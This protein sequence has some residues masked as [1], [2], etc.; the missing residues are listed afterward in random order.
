MTGIER[1]SGGVLVANRG[2]IAV[3]ILRSISELGIRSCAVYAEDEPDAPH[4]SQ[5]DTAIALVG[6]GV[7]AYLDID[8]IIVAATE[9]GCSAIHPGYGFL[10][11]NAEFARRCE[12]NGLIFIG[13][14]P[15]ELAVFGDKTRARRV[16]RKLGIPVAEGT[17]EPVDLA[18]ARRFMANLAPA[19]SVF[20]KAVMGGGGRG[21]R[22][23]RD[24]DELDAAYLD[25]RSEGE[26]AFGETRLYA[27][28]AIPNARH[29]EVQIIGDEAGAVGHLGERDC[30]VQRRNQK[31]IEVAP[32]VSLGEDL[33]AALLEAALRM[34]RSIHFRGVGTIE[35]LVAPDGKFVFLEGNPRLQVEHTVTE[36]VTGV[37]LVAAQL[38]IAGGASLAELGL[39]RPP[40]ARGFAIQLRVNAVDPD[41][42]VVGRFEPPT[43]AGIRVDTHCHKGYRINPRYDPLLAKVIV[44]CPADDFGVTVTKARHA[45]EQL[46]IDIATNTDLLHAIVQRD[47][48]RSGVVD[49]SFVENM[50]AAAQPTATSA[51]GTITLSA[52]MPG[53]VVH[54]DVTAGSSLRGGETVAVVEAM[55]MQTVVS[56]PASGRIVEL[57]ATE[58]DRVA[59]GDPIAILK[60]EGPQYAA[61]ASVRSEGETIRSDLAEV[62]HRQALTRD[63]ARPGAVAAR[64]EK[65][66]RTSRENILDLCDADSFTE[67]GSLAIAS[68]RQRRS[69]LLEATPADGLVCGIGRVDGE[70][71]TV[72]SYDYTVLAGTQGAQAHRKKDRLFELVERLRT[73]L[74]FFTEGGGGRPGET[75]YPGVGHGDVPTFALFARLSGLVPTVGIASGRCFAGNAAL[76]GCCDTIIATADATIGMAGPEM[77]AGAGLGDWTPE[78]IGPVSVHVRS[79]V[80]DLLVA[81]DAAAVAV[82]KKYLGYFRGPQPEWEAADQRLLRAIVP[83][84]RL[85]GYEV[86]A[87][88]DILCDTDSVLELRRGFGIGIVTALARIAGRPIGVIANNS[89]HLGGAIDAEAADKAAR[90][91]RLCDAHDIPVLFLCDTPGFM[92]GPEAEREAQVRKFARLF[93]VGANLTVPTFTVVLRKGYGLGA[94]AM[95]GGSWRSPIFTNAWPTGEFGGMGVEGGVRLGHKHELEAESDPDKHQALYRS[96]V[97]AEYRRG[98]ALN[99]ATYFEI[100]DVID[101]AETR[102]RLINGLTNRTP[103]PA[104]RVKKY[105]IDSW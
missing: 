81:D 102:D 45:L 17:D 18:G 61:D 80:V 39:D 52:S 42:G 4:V 28:R 51:D 58:G 77:V 74:V 35:F 94:I 29:I 64:H 56:A 27:E 10:S 105:Y 54:L 43:G 59:A 30:S 62:L 68:M 65:G 78:D 3:R 26:A 41:G 89:L 76:L 97:D 87:V 75:D 86:R 88:I 72:L 20:L 8:R 67:Y 32:A 46:D 90:F 92:V 50:E 5:A 44:H 40:A 95:A 19:T 9:S 53:T 24:L 22:L 21:I 16:A 12:A 13:P 6:S 47:E 70:P 31:L 73:P 101:P 82:A 38:R 23:V 25:A 100:D 55:K 83:E 57:M 49:T 79:G 93:L 33:R 104:R 7:P 60:P 69:D 98:N 85:R 71:C 63:E 48:F 11:E 14:R 1:L 99:A 15:E 37:D 91:L 66:R 103:E 84:N 36:E 34:A 96:L 2:E